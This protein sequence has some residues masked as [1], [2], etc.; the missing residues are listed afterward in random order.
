MKIKMEKPKITNDIK[1]IKNYIQYLKINCGL[2]VSLHVCGIDEI[3]IP[4]ELRIFNIHDNSY[5]TLIKQNSKAY[6]QCV[7]K[8]QDVLTK[9]SNGEFCGTCYAGVKEYVYPIKKGNE[10]IAFISISGY[11]TD[12][13]EKY[14]NKI[15]DKFLIKKEKLWDSYILLK[16]NIPSKKYIDTL[17]F[18]LKSMLEL[19]YIKNANTSKD[20]F[21]DNNDFFTDVVNYIKKNYTQNIS[22]K[23]ICDNFYCSR[24]KLSHIFNKKMGMSISQY[25]AFLRCET[26]KELL[27]TSSLSITEIAFSVGFKDSNYFT[28]VFKKIYGITPSAFKRQYIK[29]RQ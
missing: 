19:L 23:D 17:I 26:A 21:A 16:K 15:S 14:I 28:S 24:S 12:K 4:G 11:M 8:Q 13:P 25:I 7:C 9:C 22:S 2:S 1:N 5:C 6:N 10:T 29:N 20:T 27:K 3:I 18:P